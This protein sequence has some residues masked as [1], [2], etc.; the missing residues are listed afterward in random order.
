MT[1]GRTDVGAV[2][3]FTGLCRADENGQPIAALTLEHYPGMAEGR[4]RPPR[5]GS[6]A[7]VAADGCDWSC[8][9]TGASNPARSLFWW[10]RQHQVIGKPAFAA[11]SFLMDYLEDPRATPWKQVE[12]A[13]GTTWVEAKTAD[14]AAAERQR[15]CRPDGRRSAK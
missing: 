8:T 14:D 10:R 5:R 3:T 12:A 9:V 13:G 15:R 6:A 2:V 11:A 1:R 7:A 4:D